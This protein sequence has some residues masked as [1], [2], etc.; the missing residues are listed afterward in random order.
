LRK[1]KGKDL[2]AMRHGIQ[3]VSLLIMSLSAGLPSSQAVAANSGNLSAGA[4]AELLRAS[5][6][7]CKA[8]TSSE[9]IAGN[10]ESGDYYDVQIYADCSADPYY[11]R[12]EG[13]PVSL[14]R[15]VPTTGSVG[16]K[17]GELPARQIV[18]I[19]AAA[20]VGQT[21][22]L[23]YVTAFPMATDGPQGWVFATD[24][25]AYPNGL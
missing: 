9:C 21:D 17:A 11:G 10:I 12:V 18:C 13:K 15:R 14:M 1:Y 16:K 23:Y 20:Q 2:S 25:E 24:M 8:G 4:R 22:T 5:G 3:G 19:R 7:I 6:I